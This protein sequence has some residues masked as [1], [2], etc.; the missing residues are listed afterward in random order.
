[1]QEL[2]GQ[3]KDEKNIL[4]HPF[5]SGAVAEQSVGKVKVPEFFLNA[6]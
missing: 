1:M 5:G 2:V 6:L 4:F 3:G